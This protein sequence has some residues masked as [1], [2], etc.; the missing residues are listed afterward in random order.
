MLGPEA[1]AGGASMEEVGAVKSAA[2]SE[3][4][5][6]VVSSVTTTVESLLASSPCSTAGVLKAGDTKG[7]VGTCVM[8]AG[9]RKRRFRRVVRPDPNTLT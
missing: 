9:F 1:L 4:L 2:V 5:F 6:A 3:G 7:D 8:G